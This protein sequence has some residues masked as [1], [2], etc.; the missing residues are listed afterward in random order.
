MG[1]GTHTLRGSFKQRKQK[2]KKNKKRKLRKCIVTFLP[3]FPPFSLSLDGFDILRGGDGVMVIWNYGGE[4]CDVLESFSSG[5]GWPLRNAE[6][7]G[8]CEIWHGLAWSEFRAMERK[9]QRLIALRFVY[10]LR[11][12]L[13]MVR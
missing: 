2:K 13:R 12:S 11:A 1:T 4:F 6:S 9:R 8:L 5:P 7:V 3:F 10:K